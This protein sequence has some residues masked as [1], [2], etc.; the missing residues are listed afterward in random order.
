VNISV[1]THLKLFTPMMA[2]YFGQNGVDTFT[3]ATTF[4]NERFPYSQTQ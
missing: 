4:R 3:V 2:R 1:T